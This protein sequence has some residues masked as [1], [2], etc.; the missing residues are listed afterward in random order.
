VI[1][2][3]IVGFAIFILIKNV[4]RIVKKQEA[5]PAAPPRSEKLLEEIRDLLKK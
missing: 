4:N 2:F 3:L 1:N 5:A